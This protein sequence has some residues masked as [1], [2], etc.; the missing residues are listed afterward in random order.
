[1]KGKQRNG[2]TP[3]PYQL[4][5][6]MRNF[7]RIAAVL[8][9]LFM[10]V[11]AQAQYFVKSV[12]VGDCTYDL[13][14]DMTASIADVP[15]DLAGEFNIP[16]S[17]MYE[18][19]EYPVTGISGGYGIYYD[20]N[21]KDDLERGAFYGCSKLTSIKIPNTVTEIRPY[22][23]AY[24]SSLKSIKIPKSVE[25]IEEDIFTGCS[26]LTSI[27][28]EQGNQYYASFNGALCRKRGDDYI[29]LVTIPGGLTY[30][31][32][33]NEVT[34]I[35]GH[36]F[37]YDNSKIS[38][39]IVP[40]TVQ[41]MQNYAFSDYHGKLILF[42]T[43]NFA[44]N[45][46]FDESKATV[47]VRANEEAREVRSN[48]FKG[49]CFELGDVMLSESPSLAAVAFKVTGMDI[50]GCPYRLNS[51][52]QGETVISSDKDGWYKVA[53]SPGE[54]VSFTINCNYGIFNYKYSF[55]IS[56]ERI[57]FNTDK[58][59]RGQT[60]YNI[61]VVPSSDK[62]L[63][64]TE[65]GVIYNGETYKVDETNFVKFENL[66]PNTDYPYQCYG[67]YNGE[68]VYGSSST[69]TTRGTNPKTVVDSIGTNTFNISG[70]K[71]IKDATLKEEYFKVGDN[72]YPG[73]ELKLNGLAPER[74]YTVLYYVVTEEGSTEYTEQ[75]ITTLPLELTILNPQPVSSSCAIVAA[76]TNISE[77]E[78]NVGFQWRKYDAPET[79]PSSEGYA[80]I[81]GGRLEGYIKNLQ[82]TSY[83]NVRAFY[84]TSDDK[85]SAVLPPFR[86]T[87]VKR[88]KC[89]LIVKFLLNLH[90]RTHLLPF[91]SLSQKT[92]FIPRF[93]IA[94]F[95]Y[96]YFLILLI[97]S[98]KNS[99]I[100]II[101]S[102]D[103]GVAFP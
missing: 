69:F 2:Y 5:L 6:I 96:P 47:Y 17:V 14:D 10:T 41:N 46:A 8:L 89:L 4:I 20:Y 68:K 60:Y 87:C 62:T 48:W 9:A 103:E 23:F 42:C 27:E 35:E 75:K 98:N 81:Y 91:R 29:G 16:S 18:G 80:A 86:Q 26:S 59:T 22:A 21:D 72:V 85:S 37:R 79:L 28:V 53:A 49:E 7:T 15:E 101:F 58:S 1:M 13:Y 25:S 40:N 30:F 78:P 73:H 19:I 97:F 31:I 63:Q 82:S 74:T 32:V 71:V 100:F 65:W 52:T 24:C 43:G 93:S 67:I 92:A 95:L 55:T 36:A 70:E 83:Y 66:I 3:F 54:A 99:L 33:P 102:H 11:S 12:V 77:D 38:E 51:V 94:G 44:Q 64:P 84:K 56:A 61:N 90:L 34:D 57:G 39:V 88:Q 76:E 45:Y 50:A